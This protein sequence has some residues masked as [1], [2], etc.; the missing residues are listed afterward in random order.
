VKGSNCCHISRS[1]SF[2]KLHLV[3]KHAGGRGRRGGRGEGK[4]DEEKI[5]L[6]IEAQNHST[7]NVV[8][9]SYKA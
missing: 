3:K 4:K 6:R 7:V 5:V 9:I 2:I 8:I 1:E